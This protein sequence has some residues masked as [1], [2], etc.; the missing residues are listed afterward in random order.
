VLG[1]CAGTDA[2]PCGGIGT[3]EVAR[4]VV[5]GG[6]VLGRCAGTDAAPCGGIGTG[7]VARGVVRGGGRPAGD[8]AVGRDSGGIVLPRSGS[9]LDI[10]TGDGG[11]SECCDVAFGARRGGSGSTS[12][13]PRIGGIGDVRRGARAGVDIGAPNRSAAGSARSC[14]FPF[15]TSSISS[16]TAVDSVLAMAFQTPQHVAREESRTHFGRSIEI[17]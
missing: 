11:G 4:G 5:R 12:P 9:A 3:G 1:R 8:A 2:A 10:R 13:A 16:F 14:C 6:G 17:T 7:E 15:C